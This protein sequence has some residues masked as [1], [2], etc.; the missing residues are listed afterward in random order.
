MIDN[1]VKV[2]KHRLKIMDDGSHFPTAIRMVLEDYQ[3]LEAKLYEVRKALALHHSMVLCGEQ[4]SKTSEE[5]Y[6]AAW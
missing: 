3:A 5:V 4:P 1:A 6:K 2:I